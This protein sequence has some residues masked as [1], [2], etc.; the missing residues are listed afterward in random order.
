MKSVALSRIAFSF[1]AAILL[2]API[3]SL[4]VKANENRADFPGRRVGGGTRSECLVGSQ[5]LLALT[6]S[7][8]LSVT[9]N[10]QPNLFFVLPKADTAQQGKFLLKD[11]QSKTVYQTTLTANANDQLVGVQLPANVLKPGQTY[12]WNF[13]FACDPDDRTQDIVLTG[14]LRTVAATVAAPTGQDLAARLQQVE[15]YQAT[16]LSGDAIAA[17]VKLRKDYPDDAEV[18]ETWQALLK[19]LKL[20]QVFSPTI[21]VQH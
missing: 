8:N 2:L 17:L 12:R 3:A 7:N 20:D 1:G 14:W 11:D 19:T 6:P 13:A 4:P 9:A 16:G 5:Y 15:T 10:Q 18:Q 21:A